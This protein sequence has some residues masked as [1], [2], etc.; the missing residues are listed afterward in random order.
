MFTLLKKAWP[1][2]SSFTPHQ[3]GVAASS[4]PSPPPPLVSLS[5]A[6]REAGVAVG[7]DAGSVDDWK[8]F[9]EVGFLDEAVMQRKDH[10]A[11]LQRVSRLE[12]ELYDYQYNMGILLIEEKEWNS[13]FDQ[14]RQ[15]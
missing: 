9:R 1:M 8:K 11:L 13:K 12:K 14:L 4:V 3:G 6:T 2:A 10:E 7:F 5:E 15:E